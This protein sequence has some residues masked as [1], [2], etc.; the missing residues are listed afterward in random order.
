[1]SKQQTPYAPNYHDKDYHSHRAHRIKTQSLYE[2][3]IYRSNKIRHYV[4]L[5]ESQGSV[6]HEPKEKAVK[7]SEQASAEMAEIT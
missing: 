3:T 7:L 6:V 5:L 1:M 2:E 4:G